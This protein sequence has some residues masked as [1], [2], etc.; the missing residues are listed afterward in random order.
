M[1]K[2]YFLFLIILFSHAVFAADFS[3]LTSQYFAVD[4]QGEDE[5]GFEYQA[6]ILPG[7]AHILNDSCDIYASAGVALTWKKTAENPFSW[8]PELLR[9]EFT[10]MNSNMVFRFG[11]GN[12]SDPLGLAVSGLFDGMQF[13]HSS[14]AGTFSIGAWYTGFLYKKTSYIVMDKQDLIS[15]NTA[16]NHESFMDTYF[17]PRRLLMSLDWEH[18]SIADMFQL[19]AAVTAQIDLPQRERNDAESNMELNIIDEKFHSEY[20]TV[21]A[22][23]PVKNIDIELGGVLELLQKSESGVSDTV[24]AAAKNDAALAGIVNIFYKLPSKFSSSLSLTGRFATGDKNKI[25]AFIPLSNRFYGDIHKMRM[26]GSSLL[27][28]GYTARFTPKFGMS[29][30]ASHFLRH[31]NTSYLGYPFETDENNALIKEHKN[32]RSIGTE[33]SARLVW[34]LFSDLQLNL[35]GGVFLPVLG[36]AAPGVKPLY[37]AEITLAF[38]FY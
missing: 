16:F 38:A 14:I 36:D 20:F 23:I 22:V 19:K 6:N 27:S 1:R 18:P 24:D 5:T 35:G 12:Y 3:L 8:A 37:L 7:F 31:D 26:P 13:S 29:A 32:G 10:W 21:K 17:A 4:K 15:F 33:F 30:G 9:T 28:L 25:K 2:Y 11:R 34:S